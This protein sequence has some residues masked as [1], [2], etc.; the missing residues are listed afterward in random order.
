MKL[1]SFLK[2]KCRHSYYETSR[3]FL[4][5]EM[6]LSEF[7]RWNANYNIPADYFDHFLVE[8]ECVLCKN[9]RERIKL[10]LV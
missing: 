8:E 3:S 6:D 1:F 4:K 10:E 7:D 5:R 2:Q 9:K